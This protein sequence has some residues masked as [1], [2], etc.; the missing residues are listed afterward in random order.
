VE[1]DDHSVS[2]SGVVGWAVCVPVTSGGNTRAEPRTT[3]DADRIMTAP[4]EER[5][6]WE[7]TAI[8]LDGSVY[9]ELNDPPELRAK[10]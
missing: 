1:R 6:G 3:A 10:R 7:M 5:E 2:V 4:F 9:I 8:P